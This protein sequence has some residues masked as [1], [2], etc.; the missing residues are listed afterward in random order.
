MFLQASG[1]EAAQG[2]VAI[3]NLIS[4]RTRAICIAVASG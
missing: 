4:T 1:I 3:R 2:G